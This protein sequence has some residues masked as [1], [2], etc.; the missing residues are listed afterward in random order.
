MKSAADRDALRRALTDGRIATVGTDHA[1]HLLSQKQ[2]GCRKAASGMPMVQFSLPT[3][4]ELVDDGVLTIRRL[5]ELMAHNPARIFSVSGRGFLREG[6]KADIVV[7]HRGNPWTVTENIIQSKCKWSPMLGHNY[8]WRVQ[9]TICN[10]H[11]IYNKGD[12]DEAYRGEAVIF[13]S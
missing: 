3:M 13:R 4:L 1:P 10:G 11:I 5:V 12:F 6:Y 2:G 9:Q 8:R 7:V